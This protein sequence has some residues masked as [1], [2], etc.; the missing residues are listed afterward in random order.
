MDLAEALAHEGS[1]EEVEEEEEEEEEEPSINSMDD[2]IRLMVRYAPPLPTVDEE[3][4]DC[5]FT[6][7][8]LVNRYGPFFFCERELVYLYRGYPLLKSLRALE[9][10]KLLAIQRQ[11][12]LQGGEQFCSTYEIN[13]SV[14]DKV[15]Q[16][17]CFPLGHVSVGVENLLIKLHQERCVMNPI[18]ERLHIS[19]SVRKMAKRYMLTVNSAYEE[20]VQQIVEYH[21][22]SWLHPQIRASF[23][24]LQEEGSS[25]RTKVHSFELWNI[26]NL[27]PVPDSVEDLK[28]RAKMVA[29]E[30]GYA[31]G[32]TYSSLSGFHTENHS[33]SVQLV[34]TGK[35]LQHMGFTVWDFGMSMEYKLQLGA[36]LVPRDEWLLLFHQTKDLSTHGPFP[37]QPFQVQHL[38]NP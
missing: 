23:A 21:K 18:S 9:D 35:L 30:I 11:I 24:A 22:H 31:L 34:A 16:S 25:F 19:R 7:Q 3:L 13:A 5:N 15:C 8:E 36:T 12:A 38:L 4:F 33:G 20:C 29:G 6:R 37:S 2:L 14:I 26:K 1:E 28:S 27:D 17:G 32:A 10:P